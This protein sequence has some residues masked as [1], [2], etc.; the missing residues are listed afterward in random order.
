MAAGPWILLNDAKLAFE[1]KLI[2]L[3]S[4]TFKVALATSASNLAATLTPSAYSNVTHELATA[5][6]YTAAG[7][8]AGSPGLS[9]GGATATITWST[10][11][12]SWTGSGGGFVARFAYIYDDTAA[13]KQVIAYCL[14]DSTPADVTVASGITLTLTVGN[15]FSAT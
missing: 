5:A 1:K 10:S 9:G 13:V 14:L 3:S 4:D 12:V 8:T 11:S 2:D 6:G 15:V 7:A